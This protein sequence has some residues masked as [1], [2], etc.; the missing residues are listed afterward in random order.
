M[1]INNKAKSL[2]CSKGKPAKVKGT[3]D[4]SVFDITSLVEKALVNSEI[5][6]TTRELVELSIQNEGMDLDF[7]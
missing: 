5:F 4:V 6:K 3:A 1:C 2:G 7:D